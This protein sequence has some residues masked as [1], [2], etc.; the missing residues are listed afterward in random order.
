LCIVFRTVLIKSRTKFGK[1]RTAFGR[2]QRKLSPTLRIMADRFV[3]AAA[4]AIYRDFDTVTEEV[5]CPLHYCR[6]SA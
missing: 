4:T 6:G 5:N 1:Y 2:I 3:T